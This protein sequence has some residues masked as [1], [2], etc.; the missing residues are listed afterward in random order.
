MGVMFNQVNIQ[1]YHYVTH[2]VFL[3]CYSVQKEI[4][5]VTE[6]LYATARYS[7]NKQYDNIA[8]SVVTFLF[9]LNAYNC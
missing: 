5:F 3:P 9:Y 2:F 4:H 7:I 8:H 1:V 6:W